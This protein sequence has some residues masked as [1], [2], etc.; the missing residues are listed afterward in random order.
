MLVYLAILMSP[1]NPV[2]VVPVIR[3]TIVIII[4]VTVIVFVWVTII[5]ITVV[6]GRWA[7]WLGA[8]A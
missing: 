5:A 7:R 6:C 3:V 8:G 4:A 2:T 1:P